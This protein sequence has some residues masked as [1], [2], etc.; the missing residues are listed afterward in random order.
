ML[1]A[2]IVPGHVYLGQLEGATMSAE[3]TLVLLHPAE[4]HEA[5]ILTAPP[6]AVVGPS[7]TGPPV[8]LVTRNLSPIGFAR[9]HVVAERV[10]GWCYE[11]EHEHAE[12]YS[13]PLF[14]LYHR[15]IQA[16]PPSAPAESSPAS[17]F[18]RP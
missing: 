10:L 7:G 15:S 9:L 14:Q 3:G 2:I 13:S 16:P 17:R 4:L 8:P 6:S 5:V 18:R 11:P 1:A 12:D